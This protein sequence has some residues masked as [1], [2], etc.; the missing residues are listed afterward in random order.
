MSSNVALIATNA[1]RWANAKLTQDFTAIACHLVSPNAKS[2]Y[3]A[4]SAGTDVP[5]AV[6]AGSGQKGAVWIVGGSGDR[7]PGQLC[8]PCGA[9]QGLVRRRRPDEARGIQ[10]TWLRR[11]GKAIAPTNTS[12]ANTSAMAFTI[13]TRSTASPVVLV[14]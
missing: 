14:C 4:F 13:R 7:R 6:I 9:Q 5:R 1:D 3:E 10:R 8:A 2:R 12:P 11:A